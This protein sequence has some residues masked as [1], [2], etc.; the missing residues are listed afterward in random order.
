MDGLELIAALPDESAALAIVDPQYRAQLDKLAFGNEGARQKGRARLPQMSDEQIEAFVEGLWR[1]LRPSG[2]LMIWCDK[3]SVASGHHLRW[4]RRLRRSGAI[5]LVDL[6]HWNK[7]RPGMGRRSRGCSEYLV[8]LQ[9][10]PSRADGIWT[11]HRLLDSWAEQ[12]DR[13]IHPHSKPT[14]LTERLIRAVT[15]RGDLVV[16]PCAGGF[17]VLEACRLSGREFVGCDLE[18]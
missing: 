18:G 9:K 15:R 5:A 17:G 13:E 2:H 1:V 8:V 16:D 4:H 11:D 12:S 10:R 14:A 6:I 7:L 3:F